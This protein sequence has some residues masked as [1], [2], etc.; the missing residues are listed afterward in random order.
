MRP[1]T[2]SSSTRVVHPWKSPLPYLFGSLAVIFLL[3]SVALIILICS[4]R[5]RSSGSSSDRDEEKPPKPNTNSTVF[6]DE[7]KIVVIMAGEDKPTHL[8]TPVTSV[9]SCSC[10]KV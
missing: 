7:P 10:E 3:I 9:C 5:K 6:D 1:T 8:A 4:Y 2:T